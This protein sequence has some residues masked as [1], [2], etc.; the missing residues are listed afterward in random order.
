[1]TEASCF[2]SFGKTNCSMS[3]ARSIEAILALGLR[4][5]ATKFVAEDCQ[6]CSGFPETVQNYSPPQAALVEI[7]RPEVS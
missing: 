5:L 7:L 2:L 6:V 4:V 1:M 3:G